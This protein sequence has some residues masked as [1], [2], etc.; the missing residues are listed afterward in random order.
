MVI[1][2]QTKQDGIAL[3]TSLV[4]LV[5]ATVVALS[6]M[7]NSG[8]EMQMS[9]NAQDLN[10][11]FQMAESG[12]ARTMNE[13]GMLNTS[14]TKATD[15]DVFSFDYTTTFAQNYLDCAHT[16]CQL[17]SETYYRG[18]RDALGEN[19][20]EVNSMDTTSLHLFHIDS[21]GRYNNAFASVGQGL[22]RPGPKSE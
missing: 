15:S 13:Q 5:V 16:D 12:I 18:Q 9:S 1:N 11:A 6:G 17:N 14:K 4:F 7:R 3:V 21:T 20:A 8:N 2:M 22:T 19:M 10:Y